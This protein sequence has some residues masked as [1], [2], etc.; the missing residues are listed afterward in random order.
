MDSLK[1]CSEYYHILWREG[2]TILGKALLWSCFDPSVAD[3]VP[4]D[5]RIN[6]VARFITH[7]VGMGERRLAD[8]ENPIDRIG[9]VPSGRVVD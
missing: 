5:I 8:D 4:A 9:V 7:N 3:L 1:D 2:G 6:A